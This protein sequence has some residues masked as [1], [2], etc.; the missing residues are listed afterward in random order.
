MCG[1]ARYSPEHDFELDIG[2]G[3]RYVG[4]TKAEWWSVGSY[5]LALFLTI[6]TDFS[7][8]AGQRL[9]IQAKKGG[10]VRVL[11]CRGWL[12]S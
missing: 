2:F 4:A 9:L 7:M 11:G 3:W 6:L 10:V 1:C 5:L 12:S 8:A